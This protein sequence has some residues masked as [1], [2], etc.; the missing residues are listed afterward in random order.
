MLV[1]T[2]IIEEIS[3]KVYKNASKKEKLTESD[4]GAFGAC[5]VM[6]LIFGVVTVLVSACQIFDIIEATTIPEKVILKFLQS[7]M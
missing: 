1:Q 3:Y 5:I 7:Y 6:L 4:E 2:C